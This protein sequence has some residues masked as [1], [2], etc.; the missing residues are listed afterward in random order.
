MS[1][2]QPGDLTGS[3]RVRRPRVQLD[4]CGVVRAAEDHDVRG[5]LDSAGG[6]DERAGQ[7]EVVPDQR[8]GTLGQG[9][10]GQHRLGDLTAHR[11]QRSDCGLE[12]IP[13]LGGDV[14]VNRWRGVGGDDQ[15]WLP[16]PVKHGHRQQ[17]DVRAQALAV[18][19]VHGPV[20]LGGHILHRRVGVGKAR[21]LVAATV[22][23]QLDRK[24]VDPGAEQSPH[25][26]EVARSAT[27]GRDEGDCRPI[28]VG[29]HRVVAA[30]GQEAIA[31]RIGVPR[32]VSV[33]IL[34]WP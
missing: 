31:G 2:G 22:S 14:R 13:V 30:P 7:P 20:Q 12:G 18:D 29:I 9:R 23:G 5:D 28:L 19:G 26:A 4:Q 21:R 32:S 34:L 25:P 11:S 10:L 27:G 3:G 6:F 8:I 1:A 15:Q 17:A 24:Y 16:V 33:V